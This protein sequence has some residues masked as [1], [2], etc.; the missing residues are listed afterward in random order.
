MIRSITIAIVSLFLMGLSTGCASGPKFAEVS[1]TFPQLSADQGRVYFYR[2]GGIG[3]AAVQPD[4]K[5]NGKVVG[6]SVPGRFFYV[7]C[8]AGNYE[9]SCATEAE[10]KLSLA[11]APQETKYVR[12]YIQMG[13]FVGQVVPELVDKDKAMRSMNDCSYTSR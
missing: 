9:V 5:L 1:A 10:H 3:G 8:P 7:D 6:Q 4:I 11:L 12:T 2:D 13:L